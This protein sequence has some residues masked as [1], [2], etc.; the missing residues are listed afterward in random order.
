MSFNHPE[1]FFWMT[2]FVFI[3][4]YFWL[5][6]KAQ[7]E[8]GFSES[9]LEKL[10]VADHTVGLAG[11]NV[12]FLIA[13]LLIITALA[14]PTIR[15]ER[16][17]GPP[18]TLT[19]A[20]D[21]SKR[22]LNEFETMKKNAIRL[23]EQAEGAIELAAYD[24]KV[25]RIAPRSEDKTILQE[26]IKNLSPRIMRSSIANEQSVR[27]RC[28]SSVIVFVSGDRSRREVL[29]AAQ[30][31]W[32]AIPLFYFPLGLAMILVVLALSSMSKRQSVSLV[33]LALLFLG[34]KNLDA[35]VMDFKILKNGYRAYESG[36]YAKSAELFGEY[37]RLH[38][39]PQVRYNY[40]NA[41]FKAG[42]YEKARY[43]YAS[44]VTN[45]PKLRRWVQ[46]NMAKLAVK[47][48]EEL[49]KETKKGESTFKKEDKKVEKMIQI[50][51]ATPLFLY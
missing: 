29:M 3:L 43:W 14:Q 1:F 37:Q 4:F 47:T 28:S 23:V 41:L 18:E 24:V 16:L 38:D 15:G 51:N 34:E 35:G 25:Y 49:P 39:S 33:F 32:E 44:V 13:S 5:T 9:A 50:H 2:P 7:S 46:Y 21:I 30:E 17:Q 11:R 12:L 26:L 6:Q 10:R 22:P 20:L 31:K 27:Q 42:E 40:A 19:I 45:D 48:R 36:E 8:H